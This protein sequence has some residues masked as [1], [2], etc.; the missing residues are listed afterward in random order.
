MRA[1]PIVGKPDLDDPP[2]PASSN[3][4]RQDEQACALIDLLSGTG[5]TGAARRSRRPRPRSARAGVSGMRLGSPTR[6]RPS[7]N[8]ATRP[9]NESRR[10]GESRRPQT[11]NRS[12]SVHRP[13][14]RDGDDAGRRRRPQRIAAPAAARRRSGAAR[15]RRAAWRTARRA[16]RTGRAVRRSG[17]G[18]TARRRPRAVRGRRVVAQRRR[19]S[20]TGRRAAGLRDHAGSSEREARHGGRRAGRDR[21]PRSRPRLAVADS[22]EMTT[23]CQNTLR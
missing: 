5:T 17:T 19:R 7:T 9:A 23:P 22:S 13:R 3:T 10:D 2:Q 8:T 1:A 4:T 12:P 11:P 6:R 14:A 15:S 18:R 16:R 21:P 20:A